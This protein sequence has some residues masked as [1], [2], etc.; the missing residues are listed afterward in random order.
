[1]TQLNHPVERPTFP[2]LMRGFFG[3]CPSCNEGELFG[4][5]L[6]VEDHCQNCGEAYH[7]HEADDAPAYFTIMIV[8]HIFVPLAIIALRNWDLSATAVLAGLVPAIS[9]SCLVLLPR[10]KGALIAVQWAKLMH[11][12][13]YQQSAER[14]V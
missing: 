2:A 6:K 5:Y 8:G 13:D 10:I 12:F 3:R 7:H 11:G 4:R 9:I 14:T 1:V